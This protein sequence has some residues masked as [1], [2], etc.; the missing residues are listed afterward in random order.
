MEYNIQ[1]CAHTMLWESLQ[2]MRG[3]GFLV[4]SQSGKGYRGKTTLI[5]LAFH[6]QE[7]L[8]RTSIE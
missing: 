1:P 4:T 5:G 7:I 3:K 2:K 8:E 6:P